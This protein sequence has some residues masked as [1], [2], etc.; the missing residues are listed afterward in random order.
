MLKIF[1]TRHGQNRNNAD[2]TL[3]GRSDEALT[4]LGIQ[5]A[6]QVAAKIEEAGLT[7]DKVY[8]SP[9]R[10][11][12]Q[13]AQIISSHLGI[14]GPIRLSDLTERELGVMTGQKICDIEKMCVPD[15]FKAGNLTYFLCAEGAETFPEMKERAKRLLDSIKSNDK[16]GSI[17]L[18]TH[19]DIGKMLYS[20]FYDLDWK[21]TLRLFHFG[22]SDLLLL[23]EDS[24]PEDT[25]VFQTEQ[26]NA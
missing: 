14:S 4:E 8:S 24:R 22:N 20:A 26:H 9:L 15:I 12:F 6:H 13:T 11:A 16:D 5:Q 2:G 7:F 10:R 1:L 19:S 25:H 18:V 23:A 3:N 17:L 21:E